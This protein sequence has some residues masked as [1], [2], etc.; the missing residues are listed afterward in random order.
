[1]AVTR[2]D[3]CPNCEGRGFEI[4]DVRG[5]GLHVKCVVCNGTKLRPVTTF[6]RAT[7]EHHRGAAMRRKTKGQ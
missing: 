4:C 3:A 5:V 1:M 2:R 7:R 6:V